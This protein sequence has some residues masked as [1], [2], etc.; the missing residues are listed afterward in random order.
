[1]PS[2]SVQ[3][4]DPKTLLKLARLV[5]DM[6]EAYKQYKALIKSGVLCAD[7]LQRFNRLERETDEMVDQVMLGTSADLFCEG[8]G[9]PD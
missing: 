4:S 6:R 8:R 1:M 5:K 7:L 3:D 9:L 2:I